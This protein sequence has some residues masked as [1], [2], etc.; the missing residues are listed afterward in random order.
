MS[1]STKSQFYKY[2]IRSVA[3]V[4]YPICIDKAYLYPVP[5]EDALSIENMFVHFR[6]TFYDTIA[7]ADQVLEYIAIG[8][9]WPLFPEDE[10]PRIRKFE[11]NQA[12]DANRVVDV[13]FDFSHLVKSDDIAFT[14]QL[15]PDY[16]NGDM[17]FAL[18]KFPDSLRDVLQVGVIDIWKIDTIYTTR[19]IR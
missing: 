12:A 8:N 2:S 1:Q 18:V 15:T 10:P 11:V 14:P 7:P 9:T 16:D 4:D 13:K 17:T 6:F 3:Q 19:E 5:P